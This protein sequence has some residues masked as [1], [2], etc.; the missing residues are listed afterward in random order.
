MLK[1][2]LDGIKLAHY[3]FIEVFKYFRVSNFLYA[4]GTLTA[5]ALK[6]LR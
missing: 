1:F 2:A 4:M 3:N 6:I 5:F